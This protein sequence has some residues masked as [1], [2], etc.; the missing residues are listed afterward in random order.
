MDTS[1]KRFEQDIETY[2]LNHDFRKVLP[3]SYDKEKMLFP[4]ILEEFVSK[5]QPKAWA[6]YTK[7]YGASAVDKL[8]RRVNTAISESNVL[9]VLKKGIKDMGIEIKLCYFK[10]SSNLNQDL[11]KLYG[12]NICGIT[13]QFPYSK[14]NNN[15]IDTV[16]SING[17]PL[18]AFELKDQLKGQDVNNAM[19]QWK[20]DRDPKEPIFK[21]GQRFLCYFAIDLYDA[22]MTTEL[23]GEYTRFL[24]FNQG[25]NGAGNPGGKGNPKNDE[26]YPTS[27]IWE[28]V[29]SVDSMIDL[30]AKFI[31]IT[32]EK[33]EKN[34]KSYITK[35][36]IFPRYHQYDVVKKILEDVKEK[37]AGINYLIE[38]SAGS[39]KS[40]SIAWIAYRLASAFDSNDKYIFDSVI[41]VTNRIVLDSQLQDTINSFDHKAG[42]VECITQKKGSGGL[43]DAINDKKK[44][45][46]C[47]IQKFLYA[48]KDFDELKG[49]NFAV[50]I[51]E[52]HQG[53]SG[54]SARTLRSSLID[55]DKEKKAF[56]VENDMNPD[57]IEETEELLNI[58]GQGHH[59]NQSFFAFT[60]TPI[61]KTL[62]LFG[63][64]IGDEKKKPFHTYSMRQ[65]IEEGF[66]LDVLSTYVTIKEAF[67]LI[68]NTEENPELLEEKA[69][70]ALF[71]YYKQHEFTISQKVDMIMDNFLNNGRKKINGHGKAMIVTDSRQSAVL[72]YQAI[73]EYL[74]KHPAETSGCGVLVAFSGKVKFDGDDTEYIE[75]EMNE[76][77]DGRKI[78]SDSKFRKAFKS[79]DFNIMVV[80]DKYQTGYDEPLLHSMFVDKK[81]KGVNAVQTLS[82][83]NRTAP[84]KNDTFVLDFANTS[85]SIKESFQPFYEET[86]L[87]GS[88][89]V[90]RVYDLRSKLNEFAIF[91]DEDIDKFY[92]IMKTNSDKKKQDDSAI[93]K[94]VS[95]MKPAVDNYADLDDD[96][97]LLARDTMMKFIR[98]YGFVTQ[99]VRINDE[100]L[101]KDYLYIS[102]LIR[103]LPKTQYPVFDLTGKVSLEYAKLKETF[104]GAIE[105]EKEGGEVVPGRGAKPTKKSNKTDT[106]ER[107]VEKVNEKYQDDFSAADKVALDSIFQMLMGDPVVKKKLTEYAKTNDAQ[108]FIKSIFPKEF[109]R[110]LVE[111]YTKND[112]AFQRLLGNDQFQKAVMDIM[113]K[114]LYKTLVSGKED[115]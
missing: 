16:L 113:A 88:S 36:I 7:L 44:I 58:L 8:T 31:T 11:V 97:R 61:N 62:E 71:K 86:T 69:K 48:Y 99:L 87:V 65:A 80:A 66:I 9:D 109:E 64:S 73:K 104:K 75:A 26:G 41:I 79:D 47:T 60:A 96:K 3:S 102:H 50:I 70:R 4:E 37:G 91:N 30:I 110:V 52:A 39:G 82:R 46:I 18:F 84:F 21:F 67:K 43:V 108:M 13:R 5:T 101:F 20:E 74:K 68:T 27:Y 1:E 94:L 19:R 45:I 10:P 25:S 103:L 54:E 63:T 56:A 33:E 22:F 77:P 83:L 28:R 105:L 92:T 23:K 42:L 72:Y 49:R 59:E 81:L 55:V 15:T 17:I 93:G 95:V 24:P 89:D 90:N 115:K 51:D 85:D 29:F 2:F 34:G 111:C 100:D 38:H 53:Q 57:A 114:E 35:K 40:N 6:R 76:Y 14:N 107:I 98:S 112:D 32:E 106:L 12:G 78:N